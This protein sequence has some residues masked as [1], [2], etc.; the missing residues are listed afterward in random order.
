MR[1]DPSRRYAHRL[2]K[3]EVVKR[4]LLDF[5]FLAGLFVTFSGLFAWK[6]L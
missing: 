3:G 4:Y 5:L 6:V 2:L 1:L